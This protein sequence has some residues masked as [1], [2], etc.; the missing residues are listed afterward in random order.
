MK[1]VEQTLTQ[2]PFKVAE[3]TRALKEAAS[4][5]VVNPETGSMLIYWYH[6]PKQPT[7]AGP[8]YSKHYNV[9]DVV[10]GGYYRRKA[11]TPKSV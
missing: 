9:F 4:R 1:A 7:E 8:F 2:E 11:E 3:A 10:P 5:I 6:A